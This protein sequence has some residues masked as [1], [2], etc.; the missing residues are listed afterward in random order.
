MPDVGR[1]G[2][3]VK[4]KWPG[5]DAETVA[6]VEEWL[7]LDAATEI[8]WREGHGHDAD[9]EVVEKRGVY[10][11]IARGASTATNQPRSMVDLIEG[12]ASSALAGRPAVSCPGCDDWSRTAKCEVHPELS[13]EEIR[14]TV[15][16]GA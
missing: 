9:W 4:I 3:G 12:G 16:I 7:G 15:D 8:V 1:R 11:Y 14:R 5:F 2:V 10:H 6:A 13:L